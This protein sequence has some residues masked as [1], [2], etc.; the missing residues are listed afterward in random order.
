MDHFLSPPIHQR[1]NSLIIQLRSSRLHSISPSLPGTTP[2]R[3]ATNE[4][5]LSLTPRAHEQLPQEPK[6]LC[7]SRLR[8]LRISRW[9]DVEIDDALAARCISLYLETDHPL[10]GYFD[11]DLFISDLAPAQQGARDDRQRA[12]QHCSPLLVNALLYWACVR[13]LL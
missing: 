4:P 13:M 12:Y 9:T 2:D 8:N 6:Q 10:L 5:L 11:S 7:D 3:Y 1:D